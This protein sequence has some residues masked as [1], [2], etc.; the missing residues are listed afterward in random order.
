MRF[1]SDYNND[2]FHAYACQSPYQAYL[3][4]QNPEPAWGRA[5][6]VLLAFILQKGE[7]RLIETQGHRL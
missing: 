2:S 1:N 4:S 5:G 7:L 3:A 6:D